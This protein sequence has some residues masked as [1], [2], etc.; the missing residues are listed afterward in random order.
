MEIKYKVFTSFDA[1]KQ[2][3]FIESNSILLMKQEK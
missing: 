2:S 1:Y 3:V